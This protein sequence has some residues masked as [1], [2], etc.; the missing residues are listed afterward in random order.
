[1]IVIDLECTRGHRFEGWFRSAEDFAKQQASTQLSCPQCGDSELTRRPSAAYVSTRRQA[2]K[3]EAPAPSAD[4]Q[5]RA[6]GQA[7]NKT[8]A[9][10][11]EGLKQQLLGWMAANSED[12]GHQ[13]SAEVRRIHYGEAAERAIRGVATAD[14]CEALRDEGIDVLQLPNIKAETIN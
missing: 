3:N 13:F 9:M 5:S 12:V 8:P 11:V 4:R 7:S 2:G 14:E 6:P 1:M 10:S